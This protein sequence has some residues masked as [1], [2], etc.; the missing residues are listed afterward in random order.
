MFYP[1]G[2]VPRVGERFRQPALGE[3]LKKLV[4]AGTQGGAD[5]LAGI[6]AVRERFY[7]GDIADTIGAFSEK[8]GG[9]LRSSDLAEYHAQFEPPLAMTFAGREI[10]GQ[11]AGTQ[12][13][14]VMQALGLLQTFD[15]KAM[16][17]NTWR[18]VH[19]VAEALKLAF[20]DRERYYGDSREV[21]LAELLSP[22][23]LRERAAL[24]RADRAMQE[25]PPP[26]E[27]RH[28]RQRVAAPPPPPP[29][30]KRSAA[31][32]KDGTTHIA[33]IDRDSNMIALTPSGGVF[34]KSVFS[35]EL[36]CTLSTR[37]EM[38][39]LEE[40]HPNA[41]APGKRPR[42]TLIS[43]LICQRGRPIA[44]VGCP[45]GDD[46]G[47]ANLQM[48]LN[49]LVFDMNPQQAVEAPRFATE[50][51]ID[52]FWPHSYRPGVLSV[53]PGISQPVRDE[54]RGSGHTIEVVGACGI[55]AVVTRRDPDTGT[56]S[57]GA[58][59]RR[60]TYALAF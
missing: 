35:P 55:G 8:W 47:Q 52:S 36:G 23:Y 31:H 13:P 54:L 10:L 41:L 5:R 27:V 51:L 17:H 1:A 49:M 22:A 6:R 44:T 34:R 29:A 26:G 58:D 18:Y 60:P 50:T 3:T 43:Y 39:S 24:I 16:G 21:P 46:Q 11:S 30:P 25:A 9:L 56:L 19:T 20:A 37:S 7:R 28:I 45:G 42:T 38:F 4:A 12:A 15:L 59:P 14:V 40:G 2:Q 32:G 53:E 48:I 57:A 33:C